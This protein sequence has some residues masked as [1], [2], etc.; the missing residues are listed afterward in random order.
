MRGEILHL[1]REAY[2]L[3]RSGLNIKIPDNAFQNFTISTFMLDIST[4][5]K[6]LGLVGGELFYRDE[7]FLWRNNGIGNE[8]QN[9]SSCQSATR[10]CETGGPRRCKKDSSVLSFIFFNYCLSPIEQRI[11]VKK[12]PELIT[13]H[14]WP[15]LD[16]A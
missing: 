13:P 7:G 5:C 14:Y 10:P 9:R 3:L 12:V 15:G 8:N 1:T 6:F 16:Y 4:M 2:T 11:D